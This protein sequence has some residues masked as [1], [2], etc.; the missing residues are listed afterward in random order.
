MNTLEYFLNLY[1]TPKR[2]FPL[3]GSDNPRAKRFRL[4]FASQLRCMFTL[5]SKRNDENSQRV[6]QNSNYSMRKIRGKF[7]Q[8]NLW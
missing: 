2:P 7:T 5:S 8:L 4:I 1:S 6:R 3:Q